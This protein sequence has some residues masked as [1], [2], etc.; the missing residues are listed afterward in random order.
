M[1]RLKALALAALITAGSGVAHA[2]SPLIEYIEG[3]SGPGPYAW[4]KGVDFR[5]ACLPSDAASGDSIRRQFWNCYTDDAKKV[6]GLFMF[7]V[8]WADNGNTQLFSDDLFDFR[9]VKQLTLEAMFMYRVNSVVD[10][11]GGI[12]W[13]RVDDD[14]QAATSVS[15]AYAASTQWRTAPALRVSITPLEF[16]HLKGRARGVPRLVHLYMDTAFFTGSSTALD[17]GNPVSRYSAK[18]EF[19]TRAGVS[20][21]IAPLLVAIHPN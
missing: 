18:K 1:T 4:A 10:V 13:A 9:K 20:I 2:D 6:K 12:Q 14:A 7:N 19:Q 3:W 8:H 21:D 17:Y 16:L 11:G 5:V 15:P